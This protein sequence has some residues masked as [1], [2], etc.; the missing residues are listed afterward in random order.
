LLATHSIF[1]SRN[2]FNKTV[3][4]R[5][6]AAWLIFTLAVPPQACAQ[7]LNLPAPGTMLSV[8]PAYVPVMIKGLKVHP[9]NPLL[10]DFIL[11][12]GNDKGKTLEVRRETGEDETSYV[13]RL[14]SHRDALKRKPINSSNIF[15]PR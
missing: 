8:T 5:I 11:D 2:G 14:T 10:F 7:A 13:K 15:S 1:M 6:V 4:S 9:E 3:C 12:T